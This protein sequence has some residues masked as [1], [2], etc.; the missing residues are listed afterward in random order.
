MSL[1]RR[2]K[3]LEAKRGGNDLM[4]IIVSGGCPPEHQETADVLV[5]GLAHP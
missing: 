2:I 1:S 4:T 5:Q 3:A